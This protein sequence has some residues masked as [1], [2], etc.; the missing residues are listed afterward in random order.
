MLFAILFGILHVHEDVLERTCTKRF[1]T[2][3]DNENEVWDFIFNSQRLKRKTT[4]KDVSLAGY[5]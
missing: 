2:E 3:E 4:E 1:A 5:A